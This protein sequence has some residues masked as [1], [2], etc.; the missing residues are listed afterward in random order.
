[1]S[2]SN[3]QLLKRMVGKVDV[4]ALCYVEHPSL[5]EKLVLELSMEIEKQRNA[6][7][8]A[9]SWASQVEAANYFNK[10]GLVDTLTYMLSL[11]DKFEK[12]NKT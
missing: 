4:H 11:R 9:V 2:K 10:H 12:E 8:A 5:Y 7:Y 6:D 3:K 1:M